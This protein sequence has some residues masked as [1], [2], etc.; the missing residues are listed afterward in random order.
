MKVREA[1]RRALDCYVALLEGFYPADSPNG[2]VLV[3]IG[4]EGPGWEWRSDV[5]FD[6]FIPSFTREPAT[7]LSILTKHGFMLKSTDPDALEECIRELLRSRFGDELPPI[8]GMPP[9]MKRPKR[10]RR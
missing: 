9:A 6:S 8:R 3:P 1:S 4:I 10:R 2:V 5:K 7:G